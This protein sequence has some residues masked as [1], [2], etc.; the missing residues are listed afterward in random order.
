M[1]TR[2]VHCRIALNPEFLHSLIREDEVDEWN[3]PAADRPAGRKVCA[4]RKGSQVLVGAVL[5]HEKE[6]NR[7]DVNDELS[8]PRKTREKRAE[9]WS[10]FEISDIRRGFGKWSS[11]EKS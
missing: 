2:K 8:Q 6:D 9:V 7:R 1:A 3:K 11:M 10:A 5:P 4:G